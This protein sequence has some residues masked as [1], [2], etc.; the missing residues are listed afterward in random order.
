MN[1]FG[2]CWKKSDTA[3]SSKQKLLLPKKEKYDKYIE[4]YVDEN[5]KICYNNF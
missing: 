5:Q 1:V 4:K 2:I 3:K